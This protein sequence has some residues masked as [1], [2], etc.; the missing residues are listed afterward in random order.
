MFKNLI[1]IA[2]VAMHLLGEPLDRVALLVENA[3]DDMT[4]MNLRHLCIYK[5]RELLF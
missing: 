2:A 3:F 1:D 5:N 4:Y